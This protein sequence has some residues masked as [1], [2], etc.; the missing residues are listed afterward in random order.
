[1]RKAA[2]GHGREAIAAVL[3]RCCKAKG[4]EGGAIVMAHRDDD[5]RPLGVEATM[6]GQDGIKPDAVYALNDQGD[7]V[8]TAEE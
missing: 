1:M 2:V 7:F 8:E 6:V 5:G 4:G 3:G